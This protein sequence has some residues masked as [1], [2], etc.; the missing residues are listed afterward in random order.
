MSQPRY[1]VDSNLWLYSLISNPPQEDQQKHFQAISLIN[2]FTPIVSTQII[3]EVCSVLRRKAAYQEP[4]LRPAG[5]SFSR[6]MRG[7]T[8]EL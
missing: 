1:F 4:Q 6:A 7:D 8:T 2:Q 5:A 3:N